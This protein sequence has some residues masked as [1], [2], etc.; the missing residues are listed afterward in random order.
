[1]TLTS[2]S[3]VPNA[4]DKAKKT[5]QERKDKEL[6]FL[7]M[8]TQLRCLQVKNMHTYIYEWVEVYQHGKRALNVFG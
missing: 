6:L 5:C 1:M 7:F 3:L 8:K 2:Y 4:K